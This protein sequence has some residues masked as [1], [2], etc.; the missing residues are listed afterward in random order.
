MSEVIQ[1]DIR[2]ER[3]I[4]EVIV[5]CYDEQ[6]QAMGWYYYLNDRIDFPF[7]AK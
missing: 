2:E 7:K 3:I 6:E 1:D 5:D 4:M